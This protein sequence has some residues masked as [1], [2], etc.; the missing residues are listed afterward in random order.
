[1]GAIAKLEFPVLPDGGVVVIQGE[2]G[3]G[4]STAIGAVDAI[5]SGRDDRRLKPSDGAARGTIQ[6]CGVTITIGKRTS[7]S[8]ELECR[9]ID[10][11]LSVADLVDPGIDSPT[12]A[13]AK[14]IRTLIQLAKVDADRSAYAELFASPEEFERVVP[15][16]ITQTDD[17]LA[18]ADTIKKAIEKEA[19]SLEGKCETSRALAASCA[20]AID[21]VDLTAPRDAAILSSAYEKAIRDEQEIVTK[22]VN[23][24]RHNESLAKARAEFSEVAIAEAEARIMEIAGRRADLREVVKRKT[25]SIEGVTEAIGKLQKELDDLQSVVLGLKRDEY[26]AVQKLSAADKEES[27]AIKARDALLKTKQTLEAAEAEVPADDLI[28]DRAQAVKSAREAVEYGAVV[29]SAIIKDDERHRHVREATSYAQQAELLRGAASGVD[30]VLSQQIQQ[31]GGCPLR[32]DGGRL[33]MDTDRGTEFFSDL[34]DGERWKVALDVAIDA[35]G[36]TGLLGI[37][38]V[39]WEGLNNRVRDLINRHA[40]ERRATIVTAEVTEGKELTVQAM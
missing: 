16:E 35:V 7:R 3:L 1:M 18:L 30:S 12:S 5:A 22:K 15:K 28:A 21:G 26:E 11:K 32:V 36:E 24:E 39:A 40:K 33:V 19:R 37:P 6:G 25:T 34:S 8:G 23:A 14:R 13:D 2:H 10:G 17:P 31:I 29:R 38:Q 20:K 27:A 9:S 4:K